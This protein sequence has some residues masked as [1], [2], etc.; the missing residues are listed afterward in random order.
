M[1]RGAY[2]NRDGDPVTQADL[3]AMLDVNV[4]T[5]SAIE[6]RRMTP[7]LGSAVRLSKITSIPVEAFAP[8]IAAFMPDGI[9]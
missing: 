3:A 8:E 2:R 6:S 4:S 1:R 9:Q 7:S 5:I